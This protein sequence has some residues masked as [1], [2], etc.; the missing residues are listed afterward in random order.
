MDWKR[1]K[2]LGLIGSSSSNTATS[3]VWAYLSGALVSA[4]VDGASGSG[5]CVESI[6]LGVYVVA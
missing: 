2:L 1:V 3:G 6:V 5:R 4:G